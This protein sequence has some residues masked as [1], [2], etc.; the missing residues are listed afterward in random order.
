MSTKI[1]AFVAAIQTAETTFAAYA[2]EKASLRVR[3]DAGELSF[4]ACEKARLAATL[5]PVRA[6]RAVRDLAETFTD[7]EIASLPADVAVRA[8]AVDAWDE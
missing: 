1:D 2:A 8:E 6:R 5:A 4:P 7:A 3:R